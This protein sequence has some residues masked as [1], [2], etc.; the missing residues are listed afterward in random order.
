MD[1]RES[2]STEMQ[3]DDDDASLSYQ[4]TSAGQHSLL[5][6]CD[7]FPLPTQIY[8]QKTAKR[9]YR[10]LAN[11]QEAFPHPTPT[12]YLQGLIQDHRD[13]I[14]T[15]WR[16]SVRNMLPIHG[17]RK[18]IEAH[19]ETN[20]TAKVDKALYSFLLTSVLW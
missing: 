4:H 12:S 10:A 14:I 16:S 17:Y 13:E 18:S 8:T 20:Q 1:L 3:L 9:I 6:V 5:D 15:L 11:G 19:M 7:Q 2:P